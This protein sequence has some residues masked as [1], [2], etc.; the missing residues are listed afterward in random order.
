[1]HN[2]DEAPKDE[3][4]RPL[5]TSGWTKVTYN[6]SQQ[7]NKT[8]TRSHIQRF[9]KDY[10]I[11]KD[12]QFNSFKV[13]VVISSKSI[14][15][16]VENERVRLIASVIKCS[17]FSN[18]NHLE[19]LE[20]KPGESLKSFIQKHKATEE[21]IIFYD[22]WYKFSYIS[23]FIPIFPPA[24]GRF[25]LNFLSFCKGLNVKGDLFSAENTYAKILTAIAFPHWLTTR[26]DQKNHSGEIL[27]TLFFVLDRASNA[28]QAYYGLKAF[29]KKIN[30]ESISQLYVFIIFS[31]LISIS[32]LNQCTGLPKGY[33]HWCD[34]VSEKVTEFFFGKLEIKEKYRKIEFDRKYPDAI[35]IIFILLGIVDILM[36]Q[37]PVQYSFDKKDGIKEKLGL[38]QAFAYGL[39]ICIASTSYPYFNFKYW[40]FV[41]PS[42]R[43]KFSSLRRKDKFKIG[44]V[45]F[46]PM[47]I[48]TLIS[49]I[50]VLSCLPNSDNTNKFQN[51]IN[52]IATIGPFLSSLFVLIPLLLGAARKV[53]IRKIEHSYDP[54]IKSDP[55]QRKPLGNGES[56]TLLRGVTG[57]RE[58]Y[59]KGRTE[60][61]QP[62]SI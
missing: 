26:F 37:T 55:I 44:I 62:L 13:I 60:V 27:R 15:F 51:T 4:T 38:N 22:S 54:N 2:V 19:P 17:K 16:I 45:N 57:C 6:L 56:I 46:V 59:H 43:T 50:T 40:Q 39:R 10:V 48:N 33:L 28:A 58:G 32:F 24:I 5:F 52:E 23:E 53:V 3:F 1:M 31:F 34:K 36:F 47:F 61:S 41:F 18:L 7:I 29:L 9:F 12:K 35:Q 30:V 49:L 8:S 20:S 14:S 25:T 11:L 21:N 42:Y